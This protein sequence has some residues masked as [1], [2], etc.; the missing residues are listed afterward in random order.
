MFKKIEQYIYFIFIHFQARYFW[1]NRGNWNF[2]KFK[3]IGPFE[4]DYENWGSSTFNLGEYVVCK[5]RYITNEITVNS[6]VWNKDF[7]EYMTKLNTI[8]DQTK[9]ENE[10]KKKASIEETLKKKS[11]EIQNMLKKSP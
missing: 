4:F 5:K 3:E 8:I 7:S 9:E 10:A 6:D 2:S 11:A 1:K